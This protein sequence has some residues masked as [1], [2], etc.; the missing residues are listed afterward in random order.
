MALL[1]VIEK[2]HDTLA[3]KRDAENLYLGEYLWCQPIRL[4][5]DLNL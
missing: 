1:D 4:K 2:N 5:S 3:A